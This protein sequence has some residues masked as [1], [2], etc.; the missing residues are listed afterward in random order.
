MQR[1]NQSVNQNEFFATQKQNESL[2]RVMDL[3]R[4][5]KLIDRKQGSE[6]VPKECSYRFYHLRIGTTRPQGENI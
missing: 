6:G 4:M 5:T 2:I 1:S 3:H